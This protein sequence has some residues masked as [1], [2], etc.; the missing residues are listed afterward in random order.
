MSLVIFLLVA[1]MTTGLYF[2]TAVG[3]WK[4]G[5]SAS[6][7]LRSVYVAQRTYLADHPTTPVTSLTE[8]DLRP[9]LPNNASTF[10]KVAGLDGVE[11]SINVKVSPPVILNGSNGIYDPSGNPNDSLWDVGE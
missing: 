3:D 1:L 5:R 2:S 4:L 11:R 9:Y 6:E 7:T 10:P 8:S